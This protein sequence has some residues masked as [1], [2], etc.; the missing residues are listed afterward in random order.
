MINSINKMITNGKMRSSSNKISNAGR[1]YLYYTI[2]HT[3]YNLTD[4]RGSFNSNALPWLRYHGNGTHLCDRLS[5]TFAVCSVLRFETYSI[6]RIRKSY[7]VHLA[8]PTRPRAIFTSSAHQRN[9]L[10]HG[11]AIQTLLGNGS[12]NNR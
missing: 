3:G 11:G 7:N 4:I 1:S 9:H 12:A 2:S 8:V 10:R 5:K 6:V